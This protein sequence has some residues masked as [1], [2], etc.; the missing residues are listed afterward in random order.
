MS[1]LF[2]LSATMTADKFSLFG[3]SARMTADK[4]GDWFIPRARSKTFSYWGYFDVFRPGAEDGEK[5]HG[6]RPHS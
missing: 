5:F 3:L 6:I 1:G 2:S 4:F